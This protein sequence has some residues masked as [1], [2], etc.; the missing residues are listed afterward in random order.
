MVGLWLA[1]GWAM[2]LLCLRMVTYFPVCDESQFRWIVWSSGAALFCGSVLQR[3]HGTAGE[4]QLAPP[5]PPGAASAPSFPTVGMRDTACPWAR[6][7]RRRPPPLPPARIMFHPASLAQMVKAHRFRWTAAWRC[8]RATMPLHGGEVQYRKVRGR[9]T[10]VPKVPQSLQ[11]K[12]SMRI[13]GT[14][15]IFDDD[16][17]DAFERAVAMAEEL[18]LGDEHIDRANFDELASDDE[19]AQRASQELE[20]SRAYK[21]KGDFK[22]GTRCQVNGTLAP[23]APRE[24][25]KFHWDWDFCSQKLTV[26]IQEKNYRV[27]MENS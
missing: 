15:Y 27:Y 22:Y 17:D 4:S 14:Q 7:L 12:G 6:R 24:I 3:G 5:H 8:A 1:Y 16:I 26:S 19:A 2:V 18:E 20:Q 13:S 25:G 23:Q 10:V 21:T 9:S 11:L